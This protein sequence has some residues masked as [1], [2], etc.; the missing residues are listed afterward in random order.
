MLSQ[1]YY[2][3]QY[4]NISK[5]FIGLRFSRAISKHNH[6][7]ENTPKAGG[8]MRWHDFWYVLLCFFWLDHLPSPSASKVKSINRYK[9]WIEANGQ[10]GNNTQ[11]HAYHIL[12]Q[13]ALSWSD[14]TSLHPHTNMIKHGITWQKVARLQDLLGMSALHSPTDIYA[15]LD[16]CGC[17]LIPHLPGEGC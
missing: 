14:S 2:I 17:G 4:L 12:N 9:S 11:S 15:N 16:S 1:P 13:P 7:L 3:I 10:R 6:R 5:P 8:D